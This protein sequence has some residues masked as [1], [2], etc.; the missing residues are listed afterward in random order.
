MVVIYSTTTFMSLSVLRDYELLQSVLTISPGTSLYPIDLAILENSVV[1]VNGF[2]SF[3]LFLTTTEGSVVFTNR[4]TVITIY[5]ND[6]KLTK[7]MQTLLTWR[8]LVEKHSAIN[9]HS[10]CADPM[11]EGC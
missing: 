3:S 7:L 9:T 8:F 4:T 2:R 1:E 11:K 6:C 10:C 5:D